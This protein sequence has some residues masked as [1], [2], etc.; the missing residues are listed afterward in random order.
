MLGKS[1]LSSESFP[2][3]SAFSLGAFEITHMQSA[4]QT[5]LVGRKR[6]CLNVDVVL[7]SSQLEK[8][9]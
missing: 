3:A 2:E 6:V 5:S 8:D 1:P 4:A 9:E 7:W